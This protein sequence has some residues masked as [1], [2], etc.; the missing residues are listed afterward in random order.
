MG[1][2]AAFRA[3]FPALE[4][5]TYLNT[6]TAAPAARPVLQA[7][8]RAERE[9]EEGTFDWQAWE[10]E[11]H[12]TR[13]LFARLIGAE[14]SSVALVSSVSEAAATVAR[15]LRLP[16]RVVVGARE[17]Q[18]NL[19]PW[20]ALRERGFTVTEVAAD[21]NDVVATDALVGAID[22]RTTLVAV[23]EVQSASGFRV[24]VPEIAR[25]AHAVGARLFLSVIQSVGALRIDLRESE[26]DFVVSH[27]YKWLLAPRGAAWLYVRPDRLP[28]LEPLAPNWKSV[29]S[30]YEDYYGPSVLAPDARR[31][32]TSLAWFP[33]VGAKAALELL[34]AQDPA[35]IE[36][37]ALSL[38]GAFRDGARALG[39]VLVPE[40]APSHVVAV[41]VPDPERLRASLARDRVVAAVRSRYLRVGFH[42]FN[43]GADVSAALRALASARPEAKL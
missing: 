28:E 43:D 23:S 34:L 24:R 9:W 6:A 33:W 14:A 30:P 13:G 4:R 25:R 29:A 27:G 37:R 18:S 16:G 41:V 38:A 20:L 15:S 32:D 31:L 5:F 26:V 39:L 11:A 12:A 40:D 19:L 3:L 42:A 7:L 8:R 36:E 10:A 1:D 22:E 35:A 17:F 2:L 21:A